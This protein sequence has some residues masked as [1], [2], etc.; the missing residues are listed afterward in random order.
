M[1]KGED[2]ENEL[3]ASRISGVEAITCPSLTVSMIHAADDILFRSHWLCKRA[4][5]VKQVL[6]SAHGNA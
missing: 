6:S 5:V 3:C 4:E 2:W 1:L